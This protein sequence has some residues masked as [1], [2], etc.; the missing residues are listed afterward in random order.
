[1]EKLSAT[2]QC[3][4]PIILMREERTPITKNDATLSIR[5]ALPLSPPVNASSTAPYRSSEKISVT[6]RN[7]R[8]SIF[9]GLKSWHRGTVIGA[10]AAGA[11]CRRRRG[12][13]GR[14]HEHC[15]F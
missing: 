13:S 9:G 15:Q 10:A 1:M 5:R 8:Q 6:W 11:P 4:K 12:V 14:G 3:P 2:F 7:T